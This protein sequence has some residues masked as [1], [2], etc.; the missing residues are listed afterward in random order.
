MTLVLSPSSLASFREC[1]YRYYLHYVLG[2]E[3]ERSY[4]SV[5]GIAVHAAVEAFLKGRL[6][7]EPITVD[8]AVDIYHLVMGLEL[9]G[10][11]AT[12]AHPKYWVAGE[13]V[14]RGYLDIVG[15]PAYVE[16]PIAIT[17]NGVEIVMHPDHGDIFGVVH[18][19]KVKDSKPQFIDAYADAMNTYALGHRALTGSVEKDVQLDV[20]IALKRDPPYMLPISNGGPVSSYAIGKTVQRYMDAAEDIAAERFEPTGLEKPMACR[21]CHV[22]NACVYV[23][24][25]TP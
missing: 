2:V 16:E 6:S 24:E 7:W 15:E 20:M 3:E 17:A 4:Q 18:D 19:L 10:V 12:K 8:E 25:E 11:D 5:R 14:V 21:F 1:H 22:R 23:N 9:I 13:K